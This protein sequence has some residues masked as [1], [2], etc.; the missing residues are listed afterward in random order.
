MKGTSRRPAGV[1]GCAQTT[2]VISQRERRTGR[3]AVVGP[4]TST[5]NVIIS[6]FPRCRRRGG[7]AANS[8]LSG[9][10]R[11][12]VIPAGLI[13]FRKNRGARLGYGD[14]HRKQD[15]LL[16]RESSCRRL[17][18]RCS[19]CS[20]P[21]SSHRA[22]VAELSR[23]C[24]RQDSAPASSPRLQPRDDPGRISS[25]ASGR[26]RARAEAFREG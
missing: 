17:A 3:V 6:V 7:R 1:E 18:C 25:G 13:G 8:N 2:E 22:K 19:I 5:G 24:L 4:D 26:A 12:N 11:A 20:R 9:R 15:H 21:D 10:V 16:C 14:L 23:V